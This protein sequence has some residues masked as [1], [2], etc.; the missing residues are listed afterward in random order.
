[1]RTKI[2][3]HTYA[4]HKY[5]KK[6]ECES[7]VVIYISTIILQVYC[8]HKMWSILHEYYISKK[9]KVWNTMRYIRMNSAKRAHELQ[10]E[11]SR[12]KQGAQKK[13]ASDGLPMIH[14]ITVHFWSA[15]G[16]IHKLQVLKSEHA[17]L[18]LSEATQQ[19]WDESQMACMDKYMCIK[20]IESKSMY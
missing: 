19:W 10:K 11:K 4:K 17:G 6:I 12:A 15:I 18:R 16:R 14:A 2:P 7:T 1:M 20:K 5:R 3:S 13:R 8:Y 9:C